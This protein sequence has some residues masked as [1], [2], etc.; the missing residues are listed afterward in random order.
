MAPG[1]LH[2]LEKASRQDIYGDGEASAVV[3][4][5][6]KEEDLQAKLQRLLQQSLTYDLPHGDSLPPSKKRK[7]NDEL[8]KDEFEPE[9]RLLSSHPPVAICLAPKPMNMTLDVREP[10]YEDT[11]EQSK[12]RRRKAKAVAVDHDQL[13]ADAHMPLKQPSSWARRVT[14][15]RSS[16]ILDNVGLALLRRPQDHRCARPPVASTLLKH[17]PYTY[18]VSTAEE[19]PKARCPVVDVTDVPRA[20][21]RRTPRHRKYKAPRPQPR[22]WTADGP[23]TGRYRR[24][25]M[26]KAV[27]A[28]A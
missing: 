15:L 2:D 24:D 13:V 6:D 8:T 28:D 3:P 19:V 7:L 11:K 5:E 27:H 18:E 22:F 12:T 23:A 9:F 10:Q 21:R 14:S 4:P 17:S 20:K 25:T 26:R 16:V 1:Y